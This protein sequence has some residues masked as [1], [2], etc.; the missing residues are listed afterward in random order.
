MSKFAIGQ[1]VTYT[2]ESPSVPFGTVGTVI[3]IDKFSWGA[4]Y[5]I[6]LPFREYI[7]TERSLKASHVKV[8]RVKIT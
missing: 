6:K 4:W 5:Q 8:R 1:R 2:G 7:A 3:R